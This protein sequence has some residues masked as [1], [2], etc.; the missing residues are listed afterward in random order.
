M[1]AEQFPF[2]VYRNEIFYRPWSDGIVTDAWE[3]GSTTVT[4]LLND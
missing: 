1:S 2:Y 3:D 4:T